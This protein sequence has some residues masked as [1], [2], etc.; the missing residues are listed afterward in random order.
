M[1]ALSKL[2]SAFPEIDHGTSPY[3]PPFKKDGKLQIDQD[4]LFDFLKLSKN[5]H[6]FMGIEEHT[7][8]IAV[9]REDGEEGK[10]NLIPDTDALV[11]NKRSVY[12]MA[13][14]ADCLP[15]SV[16]DPVKKVVAIA[17]AGWPGVANKIVIKTLEKM[18]KEF[19]SNRKDVLVYVGPSI[20]SC[21][22]DVDDPRKTE[23]FKDYPGAFVQRDGTT[24]LDLQGI[25]KKDLL[26]F[27]IS[28]ENIE[29]SDICTGCN[30][31]GFGS[32]HMER[33]KRTVTNVSIISIK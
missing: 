8:H 2:L 18:E 12:L 30:K 4:R 28:E 13:Y 31:E 6:L 21:C 5:D 32:Y 1:T 19:G 33:E 20:R 11:T 14:S 26:D 16:Y 10:I 15:V 9:V 24:Y 17:H 27:G 25:L 3:S 22:Y 23:A 7:D 29:F